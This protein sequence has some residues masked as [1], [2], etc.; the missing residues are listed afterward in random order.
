[1]RSNDRPRVGFTL[2]ELLVVIAIIAILMAL[3]TSA[4]QKTRTAAD[5]LR[6]QNN[7]KQLAIACHAYYVQAKTFPRDGS[8]APNNQTS[9]HGDN[10]GAG[11]GC[12]GD[13]APH[14]SWIAR[15]LPYI[16]QDNLAKL[17]NIPA[18]NMDASSASLTVIAT[19]IGLLQCPSD[20]INQP[21]TNSADLGGVLVGV[22]N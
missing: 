17:A 3:L 14:W 5:R 2:V 12:C 19:P 6:C 9:S 21:R 16:E 15:L 10:N 20:N 18:G 8:A 4:I 22:T 1:M 7:I 13:D 11:T